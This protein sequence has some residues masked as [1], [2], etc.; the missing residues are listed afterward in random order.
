[1]YHYTIISLYHYFIIFVNGDAMKLSSYLSFSSVISACLSFRL[2]VLL[3]SVKNVVDDFDSDCNY[4]VFHAFPASK[5]G[6][7]EIAANINIS[8]SSIF[9]SVGFPTRQSRCF[10]CIKV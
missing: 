10:I 2:V 9:S 6:I 8:D 3:L 1:M 4:D 7:D 5:S